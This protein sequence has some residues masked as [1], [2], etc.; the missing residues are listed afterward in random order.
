MSWPEAC[1]TCHPARVCDCGKRVRSANL[2]ESR[3]LSQARM[4]AAPD[5]NNHMQPPDTICSLPGTSSYRRETWKRTRQE[6]QNFLLFLAT[7][8]NWKKKKNPQK[9]SQHSNICRN[10]LFKSEVFPGGSGT[11]QWAGSLEHLR[12]P[13]SN[14]CTHPGYTAE[15]LQPQAVLLKSGSL[16]VCPYIVPSSAQ[17]KVSWF[18]SALSWRKKKQEIIWRLN[19]NHSSWEIAFWN[20]Q[21]RRTMHITYTVPRRK[22]TSQSP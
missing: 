13:T 22:W 5:S 6:K 18:S 2:S 4:E 21:W 9:K 10:T 17:I 11:E 14:Q 12:S 1:W 16:H 3:S 20:A 15:T 7:S 8:F 19:W